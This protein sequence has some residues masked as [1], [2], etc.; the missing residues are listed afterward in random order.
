MLDQFPLQNLVIA[1]TLGRV[2]ASDHTQAVVYRTS[3]LSIGKLS[4]KGTSGVFPRW[5]GTLL[6]KNNELCI[7]L[8]GIPGYL[9]NN[10]SLSNRLQCHD[11]CDSFCQCFR[12]PAHLKHHDRLMN[13]RVLLSKLTSGGHTLRRAA[14]LASWNVFFLLASP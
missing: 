6:S 4:R 12:I 14:S 10:L 5:P 1:P 13:R 11:H 8:A 3:K 9:L 7:P 2:G